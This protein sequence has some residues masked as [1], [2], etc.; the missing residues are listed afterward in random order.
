M[1]FVQFGD[2]DAQPWLVHLVAKLLA[3]DSVTLSLFERNPFYARP[4]R[5][6]R[7]AMYRYW[8]TRPAEA[9]YW[10]REYLGDA[11]RPLSRDDPELIRYLRQHRWR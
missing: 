4:P 9:S 8:F 2:L 5:F 7:A 1:W 11:L 3:G 10:H 6:V